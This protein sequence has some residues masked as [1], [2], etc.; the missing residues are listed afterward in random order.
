[1]R[2]TLFCAFVVLATGCQPT[3]SPRER[4]ADV[5]A[6]FVEARRCDAQYRLS[7]LR[8]HRSPLSPH[9]HN[10]SYVIEQCGARSEVTLQCDDGVAASDRMRE[11]ATPRCVAIGNPAVDENV[12]SAFAPELVVVFDR[13]HDVD[14]C[15]DESLSLTRTGGFGDATFEVFACGKQRRLRVRCS[16]FNPHRAATRCRV[17]EP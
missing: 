13:V 12:P 3:L 15:D 9:L 5:I 4:E 11:G 8:S 6:R 14:H 1:M 10:S 16:T 2:P 17:S 7:R